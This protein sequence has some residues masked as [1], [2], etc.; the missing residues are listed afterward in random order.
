MWPFGSMYTRPSP[1]MRKAC[2]TQSLYSDGASSPI[3]SVRPRIS[4]LRFRQL[5]MRRLYDRR[6]H[7]CNLDLSPIGQERAEAPLRMRELAPRPLRL[8]VLSPPAGGGQ[9]AQPRHELVL[10]EPLPLRQRNRSLA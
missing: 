1:C 8:A 2:S 7:P 5:S 3:M 6:E 9:V 10:A 4:V